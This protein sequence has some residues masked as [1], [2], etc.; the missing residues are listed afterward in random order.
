MASEEVRQELQALQSAATADKAVR[1]DKLLAHILQNASSVS[2]Q[3]VADLK[4]VLDTIL[5][6]SFS[7]VAAKPLLATFITALQQSL[8]DP[9][10]VIDVGEH[11]LDLLQPRAASFEEQDAQL[12]TA[13]ADAHEAADDHLA[14][15]R[16]LQG[17][18]ADSAQRP[19]P[20]AEQMRLWMRIVRN[21]LEAAEPLQADRWLTK[22]KG[23]RDAGTAADPVLRLNFQLSLART[24]HAQRRFLD[25]GRA[26]HDFAGAPAALQ[27]VAESERARALSAALVCAV[28]APAGPQRARALAR[29]YADE[30]ARALLP[31]DE[32]RLLEKMFLDRLLA[33]AEVEGFCGVLERH[34]P[35]GTAVPWRD[36][37]LDAVREHNL[38]GASKVYADIGFRELGALLGMPT[39]LVQSYAARMVEQGRLAG[40]IDQVDGL[41]RF[42]DAGAAANAATAGAVDAGAAAAGAA[43]GGA[44][45]AG[46]T[47][48][49]AAATA[50]A[51]APVVAPKSLYG[52]G[53]ALRRWH[54][55]AQIQASEL[56]RLTG[57]IQQRHHVGYAVWMV[58]VVGI[59]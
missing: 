15:A 44:G 35:P 11:A 2:P 29:L 25:A 40:H 53:D 36:V 50:T 46:G 57:V 1:F 47:N 51:A 55:N 52:Q 33:P 59:C 43:G 49:G 54:G 8:A 39:D 16:V 14:A 20:P 37:F 32:W 5:S 13:L 10:A 17:I 23:V 31:P 48:G 42:G 45:G 9:A 21:Y 18:R 12:R 7:I 3:T 24:Q 34:A 26:Y 30:R 41:I 19:L 38:I 56:E 58:L 28:L 22:A 4:A 27:L 6:E